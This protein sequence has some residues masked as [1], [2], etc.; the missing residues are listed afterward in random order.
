MAP[1]DLGD[2]S[3]TRWPTQYHPPYRVEQQ[4]HAARNPAFAIGPG[5]ATMYEGACGGLE[6]VWKAKRDGAE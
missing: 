3:V 6:G 1:N 4:R 2:L 5:T